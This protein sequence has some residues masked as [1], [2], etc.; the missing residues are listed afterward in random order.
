MKK[1]ILLLALAFVVCGC[2]IDT[3]KTDTEQSRSND[4]NRIISPKMVVIDSCEYIVC[5]S[6]GGTQTMVWKEPI[7]IHKGNC[8]FCAERRKKEQEELIRK[9]KEQ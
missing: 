1:L 7:Y 5:Y 8:K 2:S 4:E 6:V 3:T 9:I